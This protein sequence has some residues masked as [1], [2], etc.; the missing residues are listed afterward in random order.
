MGAILLQA[1]KTFNLHRLM[2][3]KA[4]EMF[5]MRGRNKSKLKFAGM[6]ICETLKILQFKR[7]ILANV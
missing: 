5:G 7:K 6:K 4:V 2:E 1:L 3:K